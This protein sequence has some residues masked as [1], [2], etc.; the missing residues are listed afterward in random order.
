MTA[1]CTNNRLYRRRCGDVTLGDIIHVETVTLGV[2][3]LSLAARRHGTRLLPSHAV[4]RPDSN[5]AS[6]L[7]SRPGRADAGKPPAATWVKAN[8]A[9]RLGFIGNYS[10][11]LPAAS[12]VHDAV[13]PPQ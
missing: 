9:R 2:S 10:D 13:A 12:A 8:L 4:A 3:A 1:P 5:A 7:P 6:D 11:A